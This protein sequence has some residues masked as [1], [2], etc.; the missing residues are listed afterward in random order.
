MCQTTLQLERNR[1]TE[2]Q[3]DSV[4]RAAKA[5]MEMGVSV[6]AG[7]WDECV[8]AASIALAASEKITIE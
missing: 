3:T 1:M 4:L 7:E 5:L 6:R 8:S 2:L